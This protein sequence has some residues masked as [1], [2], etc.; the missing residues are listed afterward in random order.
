MPFF[1]T[2]SKTSGTVTSLSRKSTFSYWNRSHVKSCLL[3][4]M[5]THF[6]DTPYSSNNNVCTIS[7]LMSLYWKSNVPVA[8]PTIS[9]YVCVTLL[10]NHQ[11][12]CVLTCVQPTWSLTEF[13]PYSADHSP[14]L[15]RDRGQEASEFLYTNT[16]LFGEIWATK[17]IAQKTRKCSLRHATNVVFSKFR[18]WRRKK[19]R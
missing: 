5:I 17:N 13:F 3:S 12:I 9:L 19:K 7:R 18:V 10:T 11:Q 16:P 14:T 1:R 4:M 15:W 2:S 6:F 8:L